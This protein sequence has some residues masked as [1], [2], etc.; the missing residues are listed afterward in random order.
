MDIGV[1][2]RGVI[3]PAGIR[4]IRYVGTNQP[5]TVVSGAS[6]VTGIPPLTVS[7][8]S[9]GSVDPEGQGLTYSW[10]F[11]DGATSTAANPTHTYPNAG[12]YQARLSVSDGVNVALGTPI[13]IQVGRPPVP[14]I[15]SP[16]NGATFRAG[17]TIAFSGSASDPDDGVLRA[18]AF[19]WTIVF[20]HESHVHPAAGPFTGI[21]SGSFVIP[22]SGHD[23]SG[24]TSYE[25]ILTV[26]DSSGLQASTSVFIQPQKVNLNFSSVPSGLSLNIDGIPY[27]T[28]FVKDALINFQYT[29]QAPQQNLGGSQY[30]FSSWSDGGAQTH[31]Y[32]VPSTN[33][34]LTATFQS[35]GSAGLVAAY[36][37]DEGTGTSTAD[38]SGN[39]RT[40][41]ISGATW[42]TQGKFGNALSF[43]GGS[44]LVTVADAPALRLTTGMTLEAWVFPTLGSGVRDVIIKEG[45]GADYYNLYARNWRGLPESNALVSGSNRTAEGP[46]LAA[47]VWTH[48][49]GTYDGSA[50]RLYVN[51]VLVATTNFA[52][53]I[54]TSTGA[55]RIGGNTLWGEY[56]QGQIDEVRIYN[57]ALTISEILA[58]MNSPVGQ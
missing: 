44:N 23:F 34:S 14:I 49:A 46:A 1:S 29:L 32:V 3:N 9:A 39:G 17:D 56:F 43:N 51:G 8:S 21:S 36:G 30:S 22:T 41:T 52:G 57:R 53:S 16:S 48:L 26:V 38:A 6:P 5:P 7:F 45:P 47:N 4:R 33:Q 10:T 40:G 35:S 18:S 58:D 28:P 2:F 54:S 24:N 12:P 55:L 15:G 19:S 42:S 31:V 37:F 13:L 27:T 25:I 50:V 20:H 11:G